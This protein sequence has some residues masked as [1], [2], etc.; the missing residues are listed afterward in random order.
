[1]LRHLLLFLVLGL[2]Q[3]GCTNRP[4]NPDTPDVIFFVHGAGG[5]GSYYDGLIRGLRAGGANAHMEFL[6]W[7]MP[8]AL[9]VMNLQSDAIHRPA[10]EKLAHALR[11]WKAEHPGARI[12]ILSHSAGGGVT[13]GALSHPDCPLIHTAVLLNPSVSPGYD[14]ASALGRITGQL[15]V[16]HSEK[17]TLFLSWRTGTFG[18]YDNVKTKAAGNTGFTGLE[19]LPAGL[20]QKLVQ[21][22][23]LEEYEAMGNDGGHFG[24]CAEAFSKAALSP[25]LR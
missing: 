24:T 14:L 19:R 4:P 10:E 8:G 13:L 20:R 22:P 2:H 17:D 11:D 12:D 1:L 9:F 16:F 25:L 6:S 5:D 23:H 3:I 7:G 21:H 15:H 18:T